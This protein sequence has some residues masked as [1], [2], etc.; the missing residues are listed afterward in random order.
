MGVAARK[1]LSILSPFSPQETRNGVRRFFA[2]GG[3][4]Q[5]E[6]EIVFMVHFSRDTLENW[7]YINTLW[8]NS[9][10]NS[11]VSSDFYAV[12]FTGDAIVPATNNNT[13]DHY[14]RISLWKQ[15]TFSL[16]R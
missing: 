3:G 13:L 10:N 9:G 8:K 14:S 6:Q 12:L 16:S 2:S 5:T 7:N 15:G 4:A 1:Q 11:Y